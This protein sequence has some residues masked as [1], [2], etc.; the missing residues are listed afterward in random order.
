MT[1]HTTVFGRDATAS[2]ER[3]SQWIAEGAERDRTRRK[4]VSG[5]AAVVLF[6]FALWL[7]KVLIL[8]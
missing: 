5:I 2:D 7:A 8:G 1:T 6:G 3:W 4:R